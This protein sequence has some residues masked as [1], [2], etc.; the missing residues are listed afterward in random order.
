MY[1]KSKVFN[2]RIHKDLYEYLKKVSKL[3]YTTM[4][5]YLVGLIKKDMKEQEAKYIEKE[6]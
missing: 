4:S 3:N 5:G 2:F 1:M 6:C